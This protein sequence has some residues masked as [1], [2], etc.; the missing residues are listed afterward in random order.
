MQVQAVI[1]NYA[2]ALPIPSNL[3]NKYQGTFVAEEFVRKVTWYVFSPLRDDI[4][5]KEAK[6]HSRWGSATWGQG[7]S[8]LLCLFQTTRL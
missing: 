1:I 5:K 2:Q 3:F 8:L 6:S 4:G 7:H